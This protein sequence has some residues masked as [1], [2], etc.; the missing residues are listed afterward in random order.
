V[1]SKNQ[2][3]TS[4]DGTCSY[5]GNGNL[6]ATTSPT[7]YTLSYDDE[8]RL[9]SLRSGTSY[10]SDFIYYGLGRKRYR[11]DYTWTGSSWV[12]STTTLY[13]YDGMRVI[14]ERNLIA[15]GSVGFPSPAS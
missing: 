5:D 8:N 2:L 15:D 11:L 13:V 14:Q 6:T 1:D 7:S 4:P 12:S 3:S 9:T 10:R